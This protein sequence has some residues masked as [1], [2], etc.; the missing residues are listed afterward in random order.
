LSATCA[1]TALPRH[2]EIAWP[3][4]RQIC[5]QLGIPPPTGGLDFVLAEG[6]LD[7]IGNVAGGLATGIT[8]Y[9]DRG[10]LSCLYGLE[11]LG[12][13]N[14]VLDAINYGSLVLGFSGSTGDSGVSARS[15]SRG[16][17][18]GAKASPTPSRC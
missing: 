16:T 18:S 7:T 6:A 4:A 9:Q 10:G 13:S 2:R 5:K 14:A 8:C 3:L 17:S 15:T 11:T 12:E 1:T